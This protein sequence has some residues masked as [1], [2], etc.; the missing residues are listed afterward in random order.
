MTGRRSAP[1]RTL[2]VRP[3]ARADDVFWAVFEGA[4]QITG[5]FPQERQ[6]R[7]AMEAERDKGKPPEIKR[8]R[9]MCCGG[10]FDSEGIHHRMCGSCRTQSQPVPV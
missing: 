7:K 3:V 1:A 2:N 8:R 5:L 4:T 6:A 9:C 10:A